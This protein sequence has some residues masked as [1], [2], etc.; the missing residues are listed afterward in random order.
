MLQAYETS[1]KDEGEEWN[2]ETCV[3][4]NFFFLA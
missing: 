3:S 4:R 2:A 1:N